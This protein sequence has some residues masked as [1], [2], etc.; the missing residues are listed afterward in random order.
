MCLINAGKFFLLAAILG[1]FA[2]TMA[3]TAD[4]PIAC[5]LNALT[6]EQRKQSVHRGGHVS[7]AI[8]A[9]VN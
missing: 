7:A 4:P 1:A 8:T 3:A 5:N 6:P 2:W 9:S